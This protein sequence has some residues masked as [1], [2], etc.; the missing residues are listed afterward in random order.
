MWSTTF[1]ASAANVVQAVAVDGQGDIGVAGFLLT[2]GI[3]FGSV[4][5]RAYT[6]DTFVAK[7]SGADGHLIWGKGFGGNNADYP[8]AIAADAGGNLIV[9]GETSSDSINFGGGPLTSGA[10][11]DVFL[12]KLAGADGAHVWSKRFGGANQDVGFGVTTDSSGNVTLTG[13]FESTVDFGGGSLTVAGA[14]TS[15]DVFVASYSPGGVHRWSMRVGGSADDIGWGIATDA[16]TNQVVAIGTFQGTVA[17][18]SANL[19]SAG[20]DDVWMM[21]MQG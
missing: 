7:L 14:A 16:A 4:V 11:R 17:F 3:T 20:V 2:G 13:Y 15:G 10:Y 1:P 9:T 5:Y 12:V 21:K 18:G 6:H 19:T 8:K